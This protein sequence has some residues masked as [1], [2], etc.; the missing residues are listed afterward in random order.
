MVH[1]SPS[2]RRLGHKDV[3]GIVALIEGDAT[4]FLVA[5][6]EFEIVHARSVDQHHAEFLA[7]PLQ[8]DVL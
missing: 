7:D 5:D 6:D 2:F 1:R 3:D 8:T 4:K